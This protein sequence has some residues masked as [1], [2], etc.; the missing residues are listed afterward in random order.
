MQI[1]KTSILIILF[2]L[3][4]QTFGQK[5]ETP[6]ELGKI[7]FEALTKKDTV[8]F[9]RAKTSEADVIFAIQ[10]V[11]KKMDK[12][13]DDEKIKE[14]YSM[15]SKSF[16]QSFLETIK[17]GEKEG[18][19]WP[20]IVYL[21]TKFYARPDS[22]PEYIEIGET[23]L[24]FEYQNKFYIVKIGDSVKIKGNWTI[25]DRIYWE[26]EKDEDD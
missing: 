5:N 19:D 13:V 11:M 20:K 17:E 14:T 22:D 18:I 21:N 15:Y 25:E 12:E 7:V 3:S 4:S 6:Q 24:E 16:V 8:L 26:G 9:E 23:Y 10:R 2:L 1:L